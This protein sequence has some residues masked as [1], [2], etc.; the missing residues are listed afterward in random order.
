MALLVAALAA[1]PG[2]RAQDAP[3]DDKEK[4]KQA[5]AA[6]KKAVD[7]F[8]AEMAKATTPDAAVAAIRN[9]LDGADPH[10]LIRAALAPVIQNHRFVEAQIA[11][12]DALG[13]YKK[14]RE[15]ARILIQNARIQKNEELQKKCLRRFGDIAHYGMSV[16]LK[17]WFSNVNLGLAREAIEAAEAVRSIRMLGPLTDLLGELEAI[18][19]KGSQ[20]PDQGPP[21]PGGSSQGSDYDRAKRKK[22]LTDPTLK[23]IN[24]LWK[25]IDPNTSPVKLY[26]EAL[27]AFQNH[28]ARTRLLKI[29][30]DEDLEDRGRKPPDKGEKK[31]P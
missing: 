25:K 17:G 22:E 15:A 24:E 4:A 18:K 21:L 23:A 27:A 28:Q 31:D 13:R 10:P 26:R 9:H 3:K 6:A 12:V 16:E 1:L 7:A 30:E 8:R 20:E 11:A 5:E 14:D 19:E 29:Q 2:A